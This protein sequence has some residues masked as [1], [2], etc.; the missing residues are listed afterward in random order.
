MDLLA[1]TGTLFQR[2]V[3]VTIRDLLEYQ[4]IVTWKWKGSHIHDS[5]KLESVQ[6]PLSISDACQRGYRFILAIVP[7]IVHVSI[8]KLQD[9][10]DLLFLNCYW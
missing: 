2:Q 3:T 7:R 6:E 4:A 9:L 5:Q 10:V 8:D 1:T